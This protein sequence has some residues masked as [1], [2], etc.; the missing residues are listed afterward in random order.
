MS[1]PSHIQHLI[2]LLWTDMQTI[3]NYFDPALGTNTN[4]LVQLNHP[5]ICSILLSLF[6]FLLM[7]SNLDLCMYQTLY[8]YFGSIF[9]LELLCLRERN[10]RAIAL[11]D[12]FFFGFVI[13][14]NTDLS[15][16]AAVTPGAASADS[17]AGLICFTRSDLLPEHIALPL[18]NEV[19][20]AVSYD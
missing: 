18:D 4:L 20:T 12:W 6:S 1:K 19:D 15:N 7:L 10:I 3:W 9:L 13:L 8:L 17:A 16:A 5:I 11:D 14:T 2:I